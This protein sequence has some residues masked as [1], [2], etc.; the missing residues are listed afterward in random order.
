MKR[1]VAYRGRMAPTPSGF[2]HL[3]HARTFWYAAQRARQR[4][5]T[6][7]LR[8]EDLD[9]DRS[10][11]EYRNAM[12]EDLR[13]FEC[14]WDEGP[15]HQS[16]RLPAYRSAM[17]RLVDR[18]W[19]YPCRCSRKDIRQAAQAPHEGDEGVLY[20]GTCLR[21]PIGDPL[22]LW[23]S[24]A[25]EG[26][27]TN[28]RFRVPEGRRID[29]F[30]VGRGRQSWVA[31]SDF[32]DFVV[33]R[34]EG[35]PAYQLAVVV[36]DREMGITEVVRGEDLLISTGRQLLLYEAFGWTPPE[37]FHLPL[38]RDEQGVRLSKRHQSLTLRR[39]RRRGVAAEQVRREHGI[40]LPGLAKL[41]AAG[42]DQ[43]ASQN[44]QRRRTSST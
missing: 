21:R 30:D 22:E 12:L 3:G 19:V 9:L 1:E 26:R 17:A 29:F 28:W 43:P 38:M 41:F 13:W 6:L 40:D 33:W 18:G 35:L 37:F 44:R 11:P 27:G 5:G 14:L 36:D 15:Y 34:Q 39:F 31:G 16:E 7:V 20:P 32:G 25:S 42:G 24:A 8:V 4:R 2:L 23:R 10:R